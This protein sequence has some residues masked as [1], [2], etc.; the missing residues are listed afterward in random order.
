M[1]WG[2]KTRLLWRG[3]SRY[4]GLGAAALL[5][6]GASTGSGV[7]IAL[8]VCFLVLTVTFGRRGRQ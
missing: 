2:V 6:A 8:G 5:L 7:T 1:S 4:C 3:A